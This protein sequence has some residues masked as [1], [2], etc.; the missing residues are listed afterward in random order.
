[1]NT[2]RTFFIALLLFVLVTATS[3]SSIAQES[4]TNNTFGPQDVFGLFF[5]A[6]ASGDLVLFTDG[7]V[8]S[9]EISNTEFV[10]AVEGEET[11]YERSNLFAMAFSVAGGEFSTRLFVNGEG[12]VQGDLNSELA[13]EIALAGEVDIDVR[14]ISSV[15][16]N[17]DI[18]QSRR[19]PNR[20]R[21]FGQVFPMF[22]RMM[23]SM[24]VY[25]TVIM[26]ND[27]LASVRLE[28]RDDINVT[29]DSS[30]FG[31]F[32][33]PVADVA[34][35]EFAQLED[36]LDVLVLQNGDRVSGIV[37]V[38]GTVQGTLASGSGEFSFSGDS[39]RDE[40]KQIVFRIPLELFGGGGGGRGE[41]VRP[42][43]QDD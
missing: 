42:D 32:N 17:T 28:G 4:S 27:Q 37:T 34:W 39:L 25:D 12:P 7:S 26:A 1:M 21:D 2:K 11:T 35:V 18:A 14:D 16:F 15:I 31:V 8:A 41:N 19:D 38:D 24:S 23:A 30:T 6:L 40:F 22:T 10:L 13:Q 5:R 43:D 29:I 9:S 3:I 36:E 20:R 33:F